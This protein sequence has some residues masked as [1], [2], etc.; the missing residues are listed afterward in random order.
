[1]GIKIA[2]V[3]LLV[4][5]GF[6]TQAQTITGVWKGKINRQKVELKII[7]N[8]DSLTGTAYYFESANNY[9]RYSIKGY[10][11]QHTNSA[12]WWDDR[13]IEERMGRLSISSPGKIPM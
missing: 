3:L 12:I 8:G 6:Y 2:A 7:Q 11:D 5:S 13:L 1:M 10:F 4:I 9:R